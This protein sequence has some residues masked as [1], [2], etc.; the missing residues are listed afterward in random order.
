MVGVDGK[1]SVPV[2]PSDRPGGFSKPVRGAVALRSP[3]RALRAAPP[4]RRGALAEGMVARSTARFGVEARVL[5][6]VCLS[7][8]GGV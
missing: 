5:R 3:S 4:V 2:P 7:L 8:R 1:G 6:S